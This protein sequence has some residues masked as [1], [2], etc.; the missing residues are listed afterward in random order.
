ML[1]LKAV[2]EKESSGTNSFKYQ[3]GKDVVAAAAAAVWRKRRRL[4]FMVVLS[5]H[6]NKQLLLQIVVTNLVQLFP[7]RGISGLR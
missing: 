6:F 1:F 3:F 7:D 2:Q 5:F 4:V